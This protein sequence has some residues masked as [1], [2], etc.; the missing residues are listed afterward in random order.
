MRSRVNVCLL[1]S[2]AIRGLLRHPDFILGLVVGAWVDRTSKRRLLVV[3][4][5]VR[6]LV[7][8]T[9]PAAALLHVLR[10]EY[11]FVVAV[12]A[13]SLLLPGVGQRAYMP[14]LVQRDDLVDANSK[15][16]A[17]SAS[18]SLAGPAAGGALSA[19]LTAPVALAVDRHVPGRGTP[20]RTDR[21]GVEHASRAHRGRPGHDA[22]RGRDPRVASPPIPTLTEVSAGRAPSLRGGGCALPAVGAWRTALPAS[23]LTAG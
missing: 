1:T 14:E 12:L 8:A 6:A 10:L 17:S 21:P 13:G 2:P 23:G 15:M 3:T 4:C 20:G 19:L 18:A 9:V 7:M 16:T 5:L 11:L 22:G